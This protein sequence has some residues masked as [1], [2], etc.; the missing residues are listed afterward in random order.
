MAL[1]RD[2]ILK[3]SDIETREVDVPEWGGKVYVRG[4][5]GSERDAYEASLVQFRGKQRVPDLANARAKLV[6]RC[7]VDEEGNRVFTDADANAL[8][9]KSGAVLDRLFE[10]ASK[11]S[12]LSDKDVDELVGNFDA[13]QSGGSTS[14]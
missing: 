5:T 13:A 3:A 8:G 1:S 10:V 9:K 11:L 12:G 14:S 4:L 7:I 6:V 2:D